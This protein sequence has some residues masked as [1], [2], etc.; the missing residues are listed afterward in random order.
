MECAQ[1]EVTG[2]GCAEPDTV[3]IPGLY[4][5]TDPGIT[6]NI[7]YGLTDYTIP[8]LLNLIWSFY[9]GCLQ[10]IIG[11]TLFSCDA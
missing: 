1:I 10:H 9:S 8:G 7:Y 2:G 11:P 4:A 6:V 5:S 3:S